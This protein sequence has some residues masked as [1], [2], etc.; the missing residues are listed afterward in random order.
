MRL[1]CFINACLFYDR[2]DGNFIMSIH[3][4]NKL[5]LLDYPGKVAATIFLGSCNFRC[6]FC[7]NRDLV[8]NP[9]GQPVIETDEVLKFLRKRQGILDGVCITG[10]EPS[11][12]SGLEDLIRQI[13]DLGFSI[14]LDT[15]GFR[16]AV[17]KDLVSKNLLDMV[18]MDIKSSPEGYSRATGIDCL[19]LAPIRESVRFLM[20]GHVPYEFRTTVVKELHDRKTFEDI[21]Q[22]IGGC[23]AYYLQAYKDSDTVIHRGFHAN[24]KEELDKYRQLLLKTIPVVGIRGID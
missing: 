19:D 16:P 4:L 15:N 24:T 5:T 6:P 2:K 7:H 13:R 9:M 3:G 8:L 21:S 14:K 10:G 20:G 17:L 18:A 1:W 11:L 22:W 12:Y 23:D